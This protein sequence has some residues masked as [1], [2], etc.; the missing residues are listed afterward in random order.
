MSRDPTDDTFLECA[1]SGGADYAV[2]ADA[3]LLSLRE[4]QGIPILDAPTFWQRLANMVTTNEVAPNRVR[5][6]GEPAL[7]PRSAEASLAQSD[8]SPMDN[9]R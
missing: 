4:V 8:H 7:T 1:V 9:R 5:R 6:A 3:D 2:S